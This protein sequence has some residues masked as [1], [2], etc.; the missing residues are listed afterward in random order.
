MRRGVGQD[1]GGRSLWEPCVHQPLDV[2]LLPQHDRGALTR[3][4]DVEE[5][6][7]GALVVY[8]PPSLQVLREAVVERMLV[9]RVVEDKKVVHVAPDQN[10]VEASA[11]GRVDPLRA[12]ENTWVRFALREPPFFQ[13]WKEGA[14]P[15]PTGLRK[16]VHGL[17]NFPYAWAAIGTQLAVRAGGRLTI[18]HFAFLKVAL[19]VCGHEVPPAHAELVVSGER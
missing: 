2:E 13:P 3:Y 5:V 19:Q 8:V 10:R 17:D 11:A 7:D 1:V 12:L 4:L 14:L 18:N 16:A 6:G 9:V 15:S